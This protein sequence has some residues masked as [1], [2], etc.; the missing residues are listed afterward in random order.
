MDLKEWEAYTILFIAIFGGLDII[1]VIG[2]PAP[3]ND[4]SN[5][6]MFFYI[7]DWSCA[8]KMYRRGDGC[9]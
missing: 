1:V 9:K 2:T 3:L 6:S 5:G 4:V 7:G 8:G